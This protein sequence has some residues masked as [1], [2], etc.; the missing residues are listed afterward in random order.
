MHTSGFRRCDAFRLPLT[1]KSTLRFRDIAE[2]LEN[3][4][5]DEWSSEVAVGTGVQQRHVK[6][7]RP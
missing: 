3:D 5:R 2:E 1:N 4:V 6:N 7:Y